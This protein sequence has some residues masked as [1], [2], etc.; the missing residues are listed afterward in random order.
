MEPSKELF[1]QLKARIGSAR[2]LLDA[3][4]D[5]PQRLAIASAA[6]RRAVEHLCS[7][8]AF[9]SIDA[10]SRCALVERAMAIKWVADDSAAVLKALS[11]E[12][13]ASSNNK[14]RRCQQNYMSMLDYFDEKAWEVFDDMG[15]STGVKK[16]VVLAQAE[17]LFLSCPD[18]GTCKLLNSFICAVSDQRE[19][20]AKLTPNVLKHLLSGLKAD[21]DKIQR[22]TKGQ[23]LHLRTLPADPKVLKADQPE[24]YS[25]VFSSGA[26][27]PC[28]VDKKLLALVE[29]SYK[30]RGEGSS[31]TAQAAPLQ[32]QLQPPQQQQQHCDMM[33]QMGQM[34]M[35]F[36]MNQTQQQQQ[37]GRGPKC[38]Q[39]LLAGEDR[40]RREPGLLPLG[41]GSS[42][43]VA[44][45]VGQG[46]LLRAESV[47]SQQ[48]VQSSNCLL[49]RHVVVY[50]AFS[51][52]KSSFV[53]EFFIFKP[54][55]FSSRIGVLYL[56]VFEVNLDIF[57]FIR[58][59]IQAHFYSFEL[60]FIIFITKNSLFSMFRIKAL[61]LLLT[62]RSS[63]SLIV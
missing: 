5:D 57:I 55:R 15:V 10:E 60:V 45:S 13:P 1:Q 32:L 29:G 31:S 22:K 34:M 33:L 18:E 50:I 47:E 19:Q 4:S 11:T 59:S 53:F 30:C 41:N 8:G 42:S 24:L 39:S 6:Q 16:A 38:L 14:T 54:L 3:E 23:Q 62:H 51:K 52:F 12:S 37:S 44:D 7:N 20:V 40:T 35:Q 26:P 21:F 63:L 25:R 28:R 61:A 43:S 9:K 27:V 17:A 56:L 58:F 36:M 46:A 2:L 48:E 49:F